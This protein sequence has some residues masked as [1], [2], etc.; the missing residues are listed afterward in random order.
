[1]YLRKNGGNILK[2]KCNK[3]ARR[4]KGNKIPKIIKT[5]VKSLPKLV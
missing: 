3:Q 4:K 1:M 5:S 2:K